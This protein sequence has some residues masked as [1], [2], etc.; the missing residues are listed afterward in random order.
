[1]LQKNKVFLIM[2]K[3]FLKPAEEAE[4]ELNQLIEKSILENKNKK[5]VKQYFDDK[6]RDE[7]KDKFFFVSIIMLKNLQH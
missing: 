4:V 6:K 2:K 5:S 3:R 7:N 1:M